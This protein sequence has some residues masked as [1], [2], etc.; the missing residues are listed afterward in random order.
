MSK[1][2][3]VR[4]R[5]TDFR[6]KAIFALTAILMTMGLGVTLFWYFSFDDLDLKDYVAISY[7]GYDT[8]GTAY[9][10]INALGKYSMFL[11]MLN[12]QIKTSSDIQNGTLQNGDKIIVDV[13]YDKDIANQ[14]RLRIKNAE[15]ETE[16][17]GLSEGKELTLDQL[18]ENVK[19]TC[20]GTAPELTVG[21]ENENTDA[22]LKSIPFEIVDARTYYDKGDTVVVKADVTPEEVTKNGYAIEKGT[23]GY[24]KTYTIDNVDRYLRDVNEVT[25]D[26]IRELNQAGAKLFGD[27]K[28]YGLRIFSEANLMPIWINNKTTFQWSNPRLQSA[29]F[30]VLKEEYFGQTEVHNNDVKLVYLVTLSQA[31]GVSCETQVVVRFTDLLQKADGTIDLAIDSGKII[32]ASYKKSNIKELVNDA[33]N[34]NYEAAQIDL[35]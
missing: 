19:I 6:K 2:E 13:E 11:G 8:H 25:V 22:F 26:Q 10:R 28:E 17:T 14:M 30:N 16:V 27:A 3:R 34:E 33:Y 29:Y 24:C 7:D 5:K 15:L 18:F 12:C 21:V 23:D 32:A 4:K 31:D 9:P 20:D 1:T 35:N